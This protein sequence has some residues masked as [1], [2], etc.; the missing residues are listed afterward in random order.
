MKREGIDGNSAAK[1]KVLFVCTHNSARSQM[2]EG[3]LNA[4]YGAKY[5]ARSAGTEPTDV[6]PL[7]IEVMR[8]IGI[9]IGH[10]RSKGID[11]FEDETFDYAVTVCD[12]ARETC[13]FFP[14]KV[15]MHQSFADP[16]TI[17]EFRRVRDEM[18][19]WIE[20]VFGNECEGD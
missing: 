10:Q 8:E 18:R 17:D 3:L 7:A 14:A 6:N 13:P 4:L 11:E 12:R 9:D 5:E 2:V 15:V 1:K 19:R 20:K 16:S